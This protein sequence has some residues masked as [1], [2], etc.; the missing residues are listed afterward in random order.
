MVKSRRRM[1]K[2]GVVEDFKED[3]PE[4]RVPRARTSS[5]STRSDSEST[6]H[7]GKRAAKSTSVYVNGENVALLVEMQERGHSVSHIVNKMLSL[8]R[9]AW[10]LRNVDDC[11]ND[12]SVEDA[13]CYIKLRIDKDVYV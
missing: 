4:L 10:Q 2:K 7:A 1:A 5:S 3:V 8:L 9:D 6:K 11:D 13:P 12:R